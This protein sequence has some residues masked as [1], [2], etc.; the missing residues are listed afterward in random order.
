[1]IS[2]RRAAF[3]LKGV[4]AP[5][6]VLRLRTTD[7]GLIE[8]QLRMKVAQLPQF[9]EDAPIVLDFS[10]LGG[11]SPDFPF[12][13]LAVVLRSCRVLP[14][15]VVHLDELCRPMATAAGLGIFRA[16]AGRAR[17]GAGAG[18]GSAGAAAPADPSAGGGGRGPVTAAS[19]ARPAAAAPTPVPAPLPAHRPPVVV[20]QA[21]RGGQVI[22]AQATDLIVLAPVNPGAQ[23]IADGHVHVYST[24]RG[25]AMAGAQGLPEARVFVQR[26]EAELVAVAGAYVGAEDIP[27]AVRGKAA[28]VLLD[29]GECR[30]VPM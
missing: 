8:R 4:M 19:P 1:V 15:A 27:D 18:A 26:L 6:T 12:G 17:E 11:G 21:V 13:A 25:R 7:I 14:V 30:I 23:V 9:F 28:Q 24:L 5:L 22:Y 2:G 3:E 16:G 29:G 10:A 20:R